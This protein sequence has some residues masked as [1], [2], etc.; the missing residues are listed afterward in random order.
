M[1]RQFILQYLNPSLRFHRPM[2]QLWQR[3]WLLQPEFRFRCKSKQKQAG[4]LP[5]IVVLPLSTD[6]DVCLIHPLIQLI[7]T[8]LVNTIVTCSSKSL[9]IFWKI[10]INDLSWWMCKAFPARVLSHSCICF[11][12]VMYQSSNI[13]SMRSSFETRSRIMS[14]FLRRNWVKHKFE[15]YVLRYL[16]WWTHSPFPLLVWWRIKR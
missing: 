14:W 16:L 2:G 10:L 9:Y 15:H 5:L 1:K 13:L 3:Q 7:K 6:L 12:W 4:S 11:K 8:I